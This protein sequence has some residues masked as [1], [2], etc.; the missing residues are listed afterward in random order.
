[1]RSEEGDWS[2]RLLPCSCLR[3]VLFSPSLTAAR[4]LASGSPDLERAEEEGVAVLGKCE[5]EYDDDEDGVA[6]E[7][8]SSFARA[9]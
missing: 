1:M 7:D 3:P 8:A 2:P 9:P 6:V 4:R 5:E